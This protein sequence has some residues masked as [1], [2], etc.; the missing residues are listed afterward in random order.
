NPEHMAQLIK[1]TP[2]DV[3][4]HLAKYLPDHELLNLMQVDKRLN[5]FFKEGKPP[6]EIIKKIEHA[7]L[8]VVS[9]G[10]N[11]FILTQYHGKPLLLACGQNKDGQLGC[12]DTKIRTALTPVKLPESFAS[13]DS[14]Q[15]SPYHTVVWGRDKQNKPILAACGLN[16]KG[17][18]SCGDMKIRTAFTTVKLPEDILSIQSV[19]LSYGHTVILGR[20]KYNMPIIALC[21]VNYFGE[22]GCGDMEDRTLFTRVK[23]PENISSIDSAQ[24]SYGHTVILGHD[25][26]NQLKLAACGLND[27]GQLGCGDTENKI[28]LILAQIPEDI[29]SIESVQ[30]SSNRTM[31]LGRDKHNKPILA[32]C[33]LNDDGQLGCG[34]TKIRTTL[35]IVKLPEDIVSIDSVQISD[36]HTVLLGRDQYNKPILAACGSND[37]GQLGCGDMKHR[38]L[39]TPVKLPENIAFIESVQIRTGR[40]VI[41]GRDKHNTPMMAACGLNNHGQLGC[42][43]TKIRTIL[44]PIQ[45]PEDMSSIELVEISSNRTVILG[46]DKYQNPML[47]NCGWNYHGQLGCGDTKNRMLL[48]PIKLPKEMVCIDSMTVRHRSLFVSGRDKNH[49]PILAACGDNRY[50]QLGVPGR[51]LLTELTIVPTPILT[52]PATLKR[53]G[54]SRKGA[55]EKALVFAAHGSGEQKTQKSNR[56][57]TAIIA[58]FGRFFTGAHPHTPDSDKENPSPKR[59]T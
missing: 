9:S 47:A 17:Q 3:W 57:L 36:N 33:G 43:G 18:L 16:D 25:K 24:I 28:S 19:Q 50:G 32:T 52:L 10:V 58:S 34:D 15:I 45:L 13:I 23:L 56:I 11:T 54:S 27:K 42:D 1:D 6:K 40:T 31:V 46:R 5:R 49:R 7:P 2:K 29:S 39:L 38:A 53:E 20:D 35:T 21:G 51:E 12:G 48:T 26:H 8:K 55:T 4:F 44:T 37:K 22:L 59:S 30:I 41:L 14:V